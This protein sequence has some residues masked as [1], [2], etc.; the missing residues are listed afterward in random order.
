MSDL[1]KFYKLA[2]NIVD[3]PYEKA[4]YLDNGKIQLIRIFPESRFFSST[5]LKLE[6]YDDELS[7]EANI[8]GYFDCV[9]SYDIKF[10][11]NVIESI[12]QL[13]N[14]EVKQ[15]LLEGIE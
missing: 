3:Y 9:D 6:K 2:L 8:P 13:K 15:A 12:Q 10:V 11:N 14:K 7:I 1:E 5:E 4:I